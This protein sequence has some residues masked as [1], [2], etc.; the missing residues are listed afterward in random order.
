M[1]ANYN[2]TLLLAK[3]DF[4]MKADSEKWRPSFASAVSQFEVRR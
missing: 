2:E 1:S 3:T 4:P